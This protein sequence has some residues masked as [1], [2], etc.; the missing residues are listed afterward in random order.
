VRRNFAILLDMKVLS[1]SELRAEAQRLITDGKMPSLDQ[2]LAAV[3][4]SRVKYTAR[5]KYAR[6]DGKKEPR[7]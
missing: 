4:E 5:I 3:A 7:Q 6:M 1:E 2:L